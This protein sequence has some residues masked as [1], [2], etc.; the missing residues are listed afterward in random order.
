LPSPFKIKK[1][2][3]AEQWE[4]ISYPLIPRLTP[5]SFR[6]TVPLSPL[7]MHLK[8][9]LRPLGGKDILHV[10]LSLFF[11][12]FMLQKISKNSKIVLSKS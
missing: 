12:I 3:P 7:K 1:K 9:F 8:I 11:A 4:I 6:W 5:L 2:R 10:N